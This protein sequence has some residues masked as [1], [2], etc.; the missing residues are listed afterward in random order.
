VREPR[1]YPISA[2]ARLLDAIEAAGGAD[3]GVLIQVLGPPTTLIIGSDS[4][5]D[6]ASVVLRIVYG[7]VSF[8][9]AGD[10]F[11]RAESALTGGERGPGQRRAE[12]RASR[13]PQLVDGRISGRGQSGG[14]GH[15]GGR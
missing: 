10:V 5:V 14:G 2:G 6:N 1:V 13:Q 8:L 7:R 9:L 4:D 3:D 12:G 15:L 11:A